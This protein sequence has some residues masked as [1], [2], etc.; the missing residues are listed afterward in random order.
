MAAT[1]VLADVGATYTLEGIA[2]RS[3]GADGLHA[4]PTSIGRIAR[5][6]VLDNTAAGLY[7]NDGAEAHLVEM[8]TK[9]N[10]PGLFTILFDREIAISNSYFSDV[11][12][13]DPVHLTCNKVGSTPR[14]PE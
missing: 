9:G 7:F 12:F 14:C 6:E 8:I 13:G 10:N 5:S 11:V 1:G 2:I 4:R 3:N